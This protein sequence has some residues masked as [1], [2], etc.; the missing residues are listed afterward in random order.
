MGGY[1]SG[2]HG[3]LASK[4]EEFSRLDIALFKRESFESWHRGTVRWSR[5]GHPMGSIG[6]QLGPDHVWL[7]Y[8][9]KRQGEP[10]QV[11]ERFEIAFT[12]QP[13]GGRR[14]WIVCPSCQRRCRVLYGAAYFRCRQCYCA[15]YPSQYEPYRLPGLS[16]IHSA[17]DRLGGDP[18]LLNPFPRKPKGMHWRTYRRLER[19][20]REAGERLEQVLYSRLRPAAGVRARPRNI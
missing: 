17:R 18:G 10:L 20:D 14:R 7:E 2:R 19:Q 16:R 15:T 12:E 3:R 1:G 11:R 6:Y 5:G 13:F 9:V 4:V 8:S